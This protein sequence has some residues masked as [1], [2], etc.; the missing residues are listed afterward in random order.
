MGYE[1]FTIPYLTTLKNEGGWSRD[2]NSEHTYSIVR[3]HYAVKERQ[4]NE[5]SKGGEVVGVS[6]SLKG[7][8][9]KIIESKEY[10]YTEVKMRQSVQESLVEEATITEITSSIAASLSA[11]IAKLSSDL[12]GSIKTQLK[13]SFKN[14]FTIQITESAREKKVKSLE[15]VVDPDKFQP[16]ERIITAK[17]YKRHSLDLYLVFVDY[18]LVEY[19]RPPL[20]VRL[21]RSKR[22]T[23]KD[24]F[25]PNI[26]KLDWPLVSMLFWRQVPDSLLLVAEKDYTIEVEDPFDVKIQEL[27]ETKRFPVK[28]PPKPSLYEVSES[29]FPQKR[30]W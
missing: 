8:T 9:Q 19:R 7:A 17:A 1:Y 13:E 16:N 28:L 23:P 10:E 26:I 3:A 6:T 30:W 21:K 27:T 14:T 24:N 22:P 15:Y 25:H 11:G 29:V 2:P 4:L 20:G 12:K 5:P 18:L